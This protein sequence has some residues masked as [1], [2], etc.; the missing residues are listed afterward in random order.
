M[1]QNSSFAS[2]LSAW[3]TLVLDFG[4]KLDLSIIAASSSVVDIG[5]TLRAFRI[6]STM[7]GVFF[8]SQYAYSILRRACSS[9][10]LTMS[11]ALIQLDLSNLK[12]SGPDSL[13]ENHFSA[14]S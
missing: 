12:S 7:N 6:A 8:S 11:F 13:K 10:E 9:Y 14:L 5:E 3:K 1:L 4:S 2:I